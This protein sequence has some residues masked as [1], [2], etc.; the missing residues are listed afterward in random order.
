MP[1]FSS[2]IPPDSADSGY[3]LIRTPPIAKLTA[4][5]IS[6]RIVGCPTHFVNNRTVPC[7][8][9]NCPPCDSGITSR[10]HAYLLILLDTSQEVVLF[11]MTKR[12]A[13]SFNHYFQRHTTTRGCHF[14]ASRLN[15]RTN[16]RVLIQTKTGD[17][18]RVNLPQPKSIENLLCHIWNIPP[19]QVNIKPATPAKP[20]DGIRIHRD[21]PE[22]VTPLDT[23]TQVAAAIA[24]AKAATTGNGEQNTR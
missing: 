16:G 3:R 15:Q 11:E 8:T 6:E 10:W 22:L 2:T 17:L 19:N 23:P 20:V 4:H 9:P 14:Q 1:N 7:E 12:A 21:H 18:T 24:A 5:V 13:A